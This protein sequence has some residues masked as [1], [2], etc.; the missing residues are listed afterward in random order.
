MNLIFENILKQ[1]VYK[2]LDSSLLNGTYG[3]VELFQ[4]S[5]REYFALKFLTSKVG[6]ENQKSE[7]DAMLQEVTNLSSMKHAHIV[8]CPGWT[9]INNKKAIVMEWMPKNLQSGKTSF[10][11]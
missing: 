3:E 8:K 1:K 2:K 11:F 5:N 4:N 9:E 10:I 6:F 7:Y